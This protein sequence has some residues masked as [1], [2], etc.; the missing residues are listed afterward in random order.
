M[1]CD[2]GEYL[3]QKIRNLLSANMGHSETVCRAQPEN[4]KT[5]QMHSI[6]S[7]TVSEENKSETVCPEKDRQMAFYSP[8]PWS[9]VSHTYHAIGF[10]VYKEVL[11]VY[12][13]VLKCTL[14]LG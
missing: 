12:H 1:P 3:S 11:H 6:C 5:D 10:K 8:L 4:L 9:Q 2:R 13:R 14:N 7:K